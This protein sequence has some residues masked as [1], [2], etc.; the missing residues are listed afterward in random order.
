MAV[1]LYDPL[2]AG[3]T[4]P[5]I[6]NLPVDGNEAKRDTEAVYKGESSDRSGGVDPGNPSGTFFPA[7]SDGDFLSYFLE[8]LSSVCGSERIRSADERMSVRSRLFSR[9]V[10]KPQGFQKDED[11]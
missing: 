4:K 3:K 5:G 10:E 9:F 7:D 2:Y 11:L 6:R 1:S 8:G